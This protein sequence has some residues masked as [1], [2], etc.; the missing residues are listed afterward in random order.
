M[1][2]VNSLQRGAL[3]VGFF[4]TALLCLQEVLPTHSMLVVHSLLIFPKLQE[5]LVREKNVLGK[6]ANQ[7]S[8]FNPFYLC[9]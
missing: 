4:S 9:M 6:L 2:G 5:P 3:A 8:Y 7:S 1:R